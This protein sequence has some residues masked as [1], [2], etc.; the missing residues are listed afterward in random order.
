MLRNIT[1]VGVQ[2]SVHKSHRMQRNYKGNL[3]CLVWHA[4]AANPHCEVILHIIIN[5][6]W[7]PCASCKETIN[8]NYVTFHTAVVFYFPNE[9]VK[10]S[11]NAAKKLS[12]IETG[13][14]TAPQHGRHSIPVGENQGREAIVSSLTWKVKQTTNMEH[15][16]HILPE[17]ILPFHLTMY[18][19][20]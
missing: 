8:R 18:K 4:G 15:L 13:N 10:L 20:A 6:L 2:L 11:A 3:L 12:I 19:T 14:V 1:N 16:L 5:Q 7:T 9:A 17:V